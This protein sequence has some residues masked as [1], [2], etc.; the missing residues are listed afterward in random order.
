MLAELLIKKKKNVGGV[1]ACISWGNFQGTVQCNPRNSLFL[2]SPYKKFVKER[3]SEIQVIPYSWIPPRGKFQGEMQCYRSYPSFLTK[4]KKKKKLFP[5]G[6]E[7]KAVPHE[8]NGLV[9][10]FKKKGSVRNQ[11]D[12]Y[13]H[14]HTHSGSYEEFLT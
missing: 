11:F 5:T 2:D 7:S 14:T 3:G 10:R 4:K 13:V 6:T 9:G 8:G 12:I 1:P